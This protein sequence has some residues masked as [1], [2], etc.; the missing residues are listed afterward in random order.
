MSGRGRDKTEQLQDDMTQTSC[1]KAERRDKVKRFY[2]REYVSGRYAQDIKGRNGQHAKGRLLADLLETFAPQD[3]R[4]LDVGC[5]RGIFSRLRSDYVG[6]DLSF[7]AGRT[8]DWRFVVGNAEALP[9]C[10]NTFDVVWSVNTLEHI[11]EPSKAIHEIRRVVRD[12]GFV[13]HAP[14]WH[15]SRFA[16]E[17]YAVRPYSQLDIKGKILKLLLPVLV[18]RYARAP[19]IMLDRFAA[20]ARY[21]AGSEDFRMSHR[22]LVPNYQR[23]WMSDSDATASLDAYQVLLWHLSRGDRCVNY[24]NLFSGLAMRGRPLAFVVHK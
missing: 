15:C 22:K 10:A 21:G 1:E 2:E 9:F 11:P 19:R 17:G 8:A 23:N 20:L 5:G 6:L 18:S 24:N 7:E 14:A 16:A 3:A 12:E 13:V 4:C